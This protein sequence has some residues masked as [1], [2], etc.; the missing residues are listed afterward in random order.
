MRKLILIS[1]ASLML[2]STMFAQ[3]RA[4]DQTG[5]NVFETPKTDVP[6][7][8]P[9][10]EFGGSIAMPY[11]ALTNSNDTGYAR[12]DGDADVGSCCRD[13]RPD[14]PSPGK[15][16]A[17]SK[18]PAVAEALDSPAPSICRHSQAGPGRKAER[19]HDC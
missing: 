18:Q 8:G 9:K 10:V 16:L 7:T 17:E 15:G 3:L 5:V 11:I 1:A 4:T 2:C 19:A 14:A 12:G 6:F 13:L